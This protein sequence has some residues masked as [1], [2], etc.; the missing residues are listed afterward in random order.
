VAVFADSSLGGTP[1]IAA[2]NFDPTRV[3]RVRQ[4]AEGAASASS[5]WREEWFAQDFWSRIKAHLPEIEDNYKRRGQLKAMTPV[6]PAGLQDESKPS[7]RV[8]F[9]KITRL[10]TVEFDEKGMIKSLIGEDE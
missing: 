3:A 9:E 1:F 6:G 8:V 4:V 7:Y 5:A 10:L 2:Q